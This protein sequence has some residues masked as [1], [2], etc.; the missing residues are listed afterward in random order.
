MVLGIT[1]RIKT[2]LCI[3]MRFH[4]L[5]FICCSF[6]LVDIKNDPDYLKMWVTQVLNF[7]MKFQQCS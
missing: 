3:F 5:E 1:E 4:I 6:S 7:L 2:A